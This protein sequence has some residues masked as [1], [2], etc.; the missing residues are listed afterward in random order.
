MVKPGDLDAGERAGQFLWIGFEGT[1]AS[2]PLLRFLR[3]IGP[4]GIILFG[5]NIES[6]RQVR[7]LTD[8]L[9]GA[10]R[11]PPF[12]ALDQEGGRVNRLMTILGPSPA[13]F[14]LAS[15]PGASAALRR[16][17]T[18]TCRALRSLGFNVNFSPVL[19]LSGR[20]SVNG[21]GDRA[22]G[23]DPERVTTL[24]R[25]VI[26]AMSAAGVLPVGKHFPGLGAAL[27]DT[28]QDLP[29]IPLSRTRLWSD[30]LLPYRRLRS[31]LPM[32]MVGHAHYPALQ[33]PRPMAA[34][35]SRRVVHDLLRV[36]I[37]FRG[38]ILTDDLEMGAIDS[39][40]DDGGLALAS[41]DAGSDGLMFCRS[42]ERIGRA[43][44]ALA[45]SLEDGGIGPARARAS[46]TRILAMKRKHL[47]GRRGRYSEGGLAFARRTFAALGAP[48]AT[49][50]DP[51]A[52]A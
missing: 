18:A 52:R 19:D 41:F 14:D 38:L 12:I 28:H 47:G 15:L 45:R 35:L 33:G 27:A 32:I 2:P 34:S 36:R 8:A 13:A 3:R 39:S 31:R 11:I 51:T 1:E 40:I 50:L 17:A 21:I 44:E 4:G 10:L 25:V 37:G 49:G 7:D 20:E 9:H 43:H 30:H 22:L 16:H 29:S 23:E 5:R 42:A 48:A 26:Q 6:P 24:A 46:L